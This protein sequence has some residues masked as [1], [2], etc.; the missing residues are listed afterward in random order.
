MTETYL[1][2]SHSSDSLKNMHR[3]TYRITQTARCLGGGVCNTPPPVTDSGEEHRA[4]L[5]KMP[6]RYAKAKTLP[7]DDAQQ[8]LH[9]NFTKERRG[10]TERCPDGVAPTGALLRGAVRAAAPPEE[11]RTDGSGAGESAPQQLF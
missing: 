8:R 5:Q 9:S 4:D 2:C 7:E 6:L 1:C 3:G 10:S 11:G